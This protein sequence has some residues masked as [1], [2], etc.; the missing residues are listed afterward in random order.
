MPLCVTGFGLTDGISRDP[1]AGI[2]KATDVEPAE[3]VKIA[4]PPYSAP[5]APLPP[6]SSEPFTVMEAVEAFAPGERTAEPSAISFATKVTAPVGIPAAPVTVAVI[7][8]CS[9]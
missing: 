8:T 2:F 5:A 3:P 4:S 1:E 9:P 6:A 7:T